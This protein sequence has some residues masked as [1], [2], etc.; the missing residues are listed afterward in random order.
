MLKKNFL[1]DQW[2]R[3]GRIPQENGKI[4]AP[5]GQSR[6]V[7]IYT[8]PQSETYLSLSSDIS[9]KPIVW[10]KFYRILETTKILP[11]HKF[12]MGIGESSCFYSYLFGWLYH[13]GGFLHL[14]G[15]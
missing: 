9:S 3:L 2:F 14:I 8:L 6:Y 11:L 4:K 10:A 7:V 5:A 12:N 15:Q 13:A 1:S